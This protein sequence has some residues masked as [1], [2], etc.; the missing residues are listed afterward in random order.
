VDS[1]LINAVGNDA[2]G[3]KLTAR[4]RAQ[5]ARVDGL[6][7]ARGHAMGVVDVA[8]TSDGKP[9]YE[10]RSDVVWD[11]I[12]PDPGLRNA[13]AKAGTLHFGP[14]AQRSCVSRNTLRKIIGL[15]PEKCIR[16]FDMNLRR[17]LPNTAVL[18]DSVGFTDILKL[19]DVALP[20][21]E[22]AAEV[23]GMR[24]KHTSVGEAAVSLVVSRLYHNETGPDK[25]RMVTRI[26][27]TWCNGSTAP[28][29]R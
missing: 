6:Q 15:A 8:L 3:R 7:I 16:F 23:A 22:T 28:G 10:I 11:H 20:P 2:Q 14:L 4:F 27:G 9:S 26:K 21:D 25:N 24:Q 18:R 17:P 29:K 5:R 1:L 19:N 12:R 13:I